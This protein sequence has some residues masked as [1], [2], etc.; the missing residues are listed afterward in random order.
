V[1]GTHAESHA[2]ATFDDESEQHGWNH[3]QCYPCWFNK[4]G[5]ARQPVSFTH[6]RN[7][8][9]CCF[10]GRPTASGIFIR[11]RPGSGQIPYCPD[12]G[13]DHALVFADP[14]SPSRSPA[15]PT[16]PPGSDA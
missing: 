10:C 8:E 4:W 2:V 15:P 12:P 9:P 13:P 6:G 16:D 7:P 5:L 1:P 14:G 3:Q 11:V